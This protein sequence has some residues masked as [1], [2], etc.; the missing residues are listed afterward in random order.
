[1]SHTVSLKS[2]YIAGVVSSLV[3]AACGQ[4]ALLV[5][6]GQCFNNL[7]G[8]SDIVTNVDIIDCGEAHDNEMYAVV[9][10]PNEGPH[11]GDGVIQEFADATCIERFE[12]FVGFDYLASEL[13]LGY[14]WPTDES[15]DAGDRT[16]QCFVFELDGSQ[17]AGTLRGAAR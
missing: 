12:D 16:V 10:Y 5:D 3:L 17:A 11:P 14:F 9:P 7:E 4:A 6:E 8:R 15:W 1:M 2:V 13:D